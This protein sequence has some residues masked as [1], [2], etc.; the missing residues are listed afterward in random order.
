MRNSAKKTGM[1]DELN[2]YGYKQFVFFSP[3]F[4]RRTE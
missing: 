2:K 1:A 4:R 3:A